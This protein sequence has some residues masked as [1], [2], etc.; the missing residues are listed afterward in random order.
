M[1]RIGMLL[2][3]VSPLSLAAGDPQQPLPKP[4]I[5]TARADTLRLIAEIERLQE[6]MV[7]H[8][9]A[10]KDRG[11]YKL[12]ESTLSALGRFDGLL[13]KDT[14]Q[15]ALLKHFDNVDRQV[16]D[17]VAAVRKAAPDNPVPQRTADRIDR[18]NEELFFTLAGGAPQRAGE[19]T[20]R[21]AHGF[22]AAARDLEQTA[23]F[24]L[25]K[26]GTDHLVL[27]DNAATL[28]AAAERFEKSLENK[29]DLA[30][31]RADFAAVNKAW[32]RVVHNLGLLAPADNAHLLRSAAR[33]DRL[34]EHLYR[35]LE[36]K[37]KRP[38]LS[39]QS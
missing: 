19:V 8:P 27:I 16:H 25:D 34:H 21:Q 14:N 13:R 32:A 7:A 17:L 2:L 9:V 39:V 20:A 6:D 33:V 29:G 11:L 23:R 24:A 3:M 1:S 31:R 38:S 22:T 35:L 4:L 18:V 5:D 37:G 10:P 26:T 28:A 36:I 12:T 15:P 30:Q